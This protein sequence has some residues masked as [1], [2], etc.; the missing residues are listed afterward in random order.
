[1][2]E[3]EKI[4]YLVL[5]KHRLVITTDT[6]AQEERSIPV[7]RIASL[8]AFMEASLGVDV[9]SA[10]FERRDC[11][12][13]VLRMT[14]TDLSSG[15]GFER[16]LCDRVVDDD[17]H[18][19]PLRCFLRTQEA[20]LLVRFLLLSF[21][22]HASVSALAQRYGVSA[23]QFRRIC[24]GI[25]GGGLKRRLRQWRAQNALHD[26]LSDHG[27]LTELA[28]RHGFASSSHFAQEI[29]FHFGARPGCLR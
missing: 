11:A 7:A 14:A 21:D 26:I 6:A 19:M 12:A 8:L 15:G 16:W 28:Y 18:I 20:Y 9:D 24:R 1:M 5:D 23:V 17:S 22:G 3:R 25:F 27:S 13:N 4:R 2:Y 10:T 29:K